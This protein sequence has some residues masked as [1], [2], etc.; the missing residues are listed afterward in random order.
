MVKIFDSVPTVWKKKQKNCRK[1]LSYFRGKAFH[2]LKNVA[3][4]HNSLP[5]QR[6]EEKNDLYITGMSMEILLFIHLSFLYPHAYLQVISAG[7]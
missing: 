7:F 3:L 1:K 2:K 4:Y 6:K 5:D